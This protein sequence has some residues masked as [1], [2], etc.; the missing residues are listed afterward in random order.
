MEQNY[1]VGDFI[2]D[3]VCIYKI[4]SIQS[5]KNGNLIHYQP[6]RGTDKVFTD[7]TPENNFIKS[8]LRHLLTSKEIKEILKE[9]KKPQEYGLI[10]LRQFKED[11]YINIPEKL[12]TDLK[13][14]YH[15]ENP[16]IKAE[17]ELKEV[18][19]DHFCLEMSFVT[20][21]KIFTIKKTIESNILGK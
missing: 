16:L 18:I 5:T 10:D 9:F 15:Q 6:I 21:K 2:I 20:D 12:I 19:L 1:K 17:E 8:G 14:F 13:Y 7:I 3:F 4:T 11:L